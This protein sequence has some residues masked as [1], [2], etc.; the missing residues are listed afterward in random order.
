MFIWNLFSSDQIYVVLDLWAFSIYC[1]G[2]YGPRLWWKVTTCLSVDFY[3]GLYEVIT[4][5][6]VSKASRS[7]D[8]YCCLLDVLRWPPYSSRVRPHFIFF[9]TYPMGS[10]CRD[11]PTRKGGATIWVCSDHSSTLSRIKVIIWR[12]WWQMDAFLWVP[13]TSG[14]DLRCVWTMCT[15]LHALVL[16]DFASIQ[17][18]DTCRGSAQTS[19]CQARWD[20]WNQICLSSQW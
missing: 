14:T 17:D 20:M 19:T 2:F 12:Y 8:D 10:R 16:H 3:E 4:S 13:G 11:T 9:W 5:I 7:T 6:D 18:T 1:W 15:K